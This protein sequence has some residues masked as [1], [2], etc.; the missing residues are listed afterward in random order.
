MPTLKPF[1]ASCTARTDVTKDLP[2][3]PL[4]LATPITVLIEEPL[5]RGSFAMPFADGQESW[6]VHPF[7]DGHESHADDIFYSP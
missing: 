7:F 3:P 4:P 2:T 6:D 5:A 1:L